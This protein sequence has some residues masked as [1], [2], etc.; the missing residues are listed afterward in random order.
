MTQIQIEWKYY[1]SFKE[2]LTQ[3]KHIWPI[4][5]NPDHYWRPGLYLHTV[6]HPTFGELVDYVGKVLKP[7][8]IERQIEHYRNIIGGIYGFAS[9]VI[10][11]FDDKKVYEKSFNGDYYNGLKGDK[12]KGFEDPEKSD[13][14]KIIFDEK[15]FMQLAPI[16]FKY[17]NS[18]KVYIG[19]IDKGIVDKDINRKINF[20]EK[21]LI[22]ELKPIRNWDRKNNKKDDAYSVKH[23]G[24]L[25]DERIKELAVHNEIFGNERETRNKQRF[26][27]KI[28]SENEMSSERAGQD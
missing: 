28:M 10:D 22:N 24:A 14:F 13:Y 8:I 6:N 3:K 19:I 23:E 1:K 7:R 16:F 17:A 2:L 26:M 20:A 21:K 4:K 5:D 25:F 27:A 15:A 12:R 11:I 9:E 18:T